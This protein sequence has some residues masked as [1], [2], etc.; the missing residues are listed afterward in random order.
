GNRMQYSTS[1]IMTNATIAGQ[2]VAVLYGDNGSDGETVLRYAS[3]PTVTAT[4]GDVTTTWDPATGDLRLNYVHDGLIRVQITGGAHPLL[5]L[6]ADTDTAK[7]FW[8]QDTSAGPVLVRG[9]HLLRGASSDGSTVNL[10]GDVGTDGSIEVFTGAT[11]V[12]WNGQPVATETTA[13]G[14]L[15]GTVPT[16]APITLPALTNWVHTEESPE[17]QP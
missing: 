17:A 14:S 11:Q 10:T 3:K 7:T 5:L 12:T 16:A 13:T 4:G 6:L 9:T 2:D 8:R 1:E 15:A